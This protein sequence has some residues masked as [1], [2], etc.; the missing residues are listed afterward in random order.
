MEIYGEI[1]AQGDLSLSLL[2]AKIMILF[3]FIYTHIKMWIVGFYGLFFQEQR[4]F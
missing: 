3:Y 2:R 1:A 4:F